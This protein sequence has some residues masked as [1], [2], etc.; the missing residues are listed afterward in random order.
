MCERALRLYQAFTS[1]YTPFAGNKT[2]WTLWKLLQSRCARMVPSVNEA[3][4]YATWLALTFLVV[5]VVGR[6]CGWISQACNYICTPF[7]WE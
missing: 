6:V 3:K 1:I 7:P 5:V 2:Y 4:P